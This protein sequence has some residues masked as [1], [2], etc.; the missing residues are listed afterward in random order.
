M[1][2]I[3]ILCTDPTKT[4][5][6]DQYY[7]GLPVKKSRSDKSYSGQWTTPWELCHVDD[8]TS[9]KIKDD[10]NII[11]HISKKRFSIPRMDICHS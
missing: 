5:T 10:I 1:K 6:F 7:D 2:S 8:C 9:F 11:R 4:L 3:K